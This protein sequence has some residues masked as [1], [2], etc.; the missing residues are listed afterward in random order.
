MTK[1]EARAIL[2]F[3]AKIEAACKAL[4]KKLPSTMIDYATSYY[5]AHIR[6]S[7]DGHSYGSAPIAR[8]IETL[9]E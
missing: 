3:K 1:T 8:A 6:Q 7:V 4:E 5:L 2:D 9:E